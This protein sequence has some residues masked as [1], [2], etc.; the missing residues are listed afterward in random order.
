MDKKVKKLWI[1][2]G[3][4]SGDI[5][6][7]KLA[8]ELKKIASEGNVELKL[9]GMGSKRMAGSWLMCRDRAPSAVS[10]GNSMGSLP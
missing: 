1:L 10:W 5:Y 6:G 4:T 8:S 9:A 2:A 7:A 3:E